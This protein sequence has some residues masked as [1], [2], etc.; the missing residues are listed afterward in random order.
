MSFSKLSDPTDDEEGIL[1]LRI[2]QVIQNRIS[3]P[4]F[5]RRMIRNFFRPTKKKRRAIEILID[6]MIFEDVTGR[7]E[8][9]KEWND[10]QR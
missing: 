10:L 7:Q 4:D 8:S 3:F 9:R 1:I 2:L 6:D 5:L